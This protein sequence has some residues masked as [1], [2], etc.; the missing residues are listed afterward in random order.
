MTQLQAQ[1]ALEGPAQ[2]TR[3]RRWEEQAA[4]GLQGLPSHWPATRL[5]QVCSK[6][7]VG[8][9]GECMGGVHICVCVHANTRAR[10]RSR[11]HARTHTRTHAHTH[12]RAFALLQS[13]QELPCL[14]CSLALHTCCLLSGAE[15]AA[16]RPSSADKGPIA[17]AKPPVGSKG[18][19]AN[20]TAASKLQYPDGWGPALGREFLSL[21][22]THNANFAAIAVRALL[23]RCCRFCH[24]QAGL[25]LNI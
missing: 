17:A 23:E 9:Y 18:A 11:T 19:A 12:T 5:Q 24:M 16:E 25:L 15:A 4:R 22:R 13:I 3:G 2:L 6:Q 7:K 1:R 14:P 8:I 20:A 10:A 21:A